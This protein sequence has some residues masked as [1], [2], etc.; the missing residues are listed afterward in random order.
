VAVESPLVRH[1][2]AISLVALGTNGQYLIATYRN[3]NLEAVLAVRD[4]DVVLLSSSRGGQDAFDWLSGAYANREQ[5]HDH[6]DFRDCARDDDEGMNLLGEV[7]D[8]ERRE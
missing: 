3:G 5:V 6:R 2:S 8:Q 7:G 1:A 4:P